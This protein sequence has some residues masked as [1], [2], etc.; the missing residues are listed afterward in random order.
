MPLKTIK[1]TVNHELDVFADMIL[2]F[3]QSLVGYATRQESYA[4]WA[5]DYQVHVHLLPESL[6]WR[7][8]NWEKEFRVPA[9]GTDDILG[10][11]MKNLYEGRRSLSDWGL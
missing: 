11:F 3:I 1:W 5:A 6:G 7:T 8:D 4:K 2:S 10:S 9:L